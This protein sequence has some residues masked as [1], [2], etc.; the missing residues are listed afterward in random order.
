M[1][2]YEILSELLKNNSWGVI[3]VPILRHD[4]K[5]DT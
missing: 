1:K 2:T 3:Y 4:I 5:S